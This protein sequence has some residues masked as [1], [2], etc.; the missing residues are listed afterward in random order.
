MSPGRVAGSG[1]SALAARPAALRLHGPLHDVSAAAPPRGRAP[2]RAA[3]RAACLGPAGLA[4]PSR[5][6]P[7]R[8]A[9]RP[10]AARRAGRRTGPGSAMTCESPREIARISASEPEREDRARRPRERLAG[11]PLPAGQHRG[12]EQERVLV[13]HGCKPTPVPGRQA[14]GIGRIAPG[15]TAGRI[16]PEPAS[17][18]RH[19]DDRLR[20]R[21]HRPVRPGTLR[22]APARAGRHAAARPRR[23]RRRAAREGRRL[24]PHQPGAQAARCSTRSC[25]RRSR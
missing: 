5:A 20:P 11:G 13:G 22:P 10:R 23:G 8:P 12:A 19:H 4:G 18:P 7:C 21:L 6:P 14:R 1:V 25:G 24:G 17:W 9:R 2:G 15:G 16:A 3:R